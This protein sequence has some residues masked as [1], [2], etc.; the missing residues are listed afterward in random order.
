MINPAT[1]TRRAS[2]TGSG[3]GNRRRHAFRWTLHHGSEVKETTN[4]GGSGPLGEARRYQT[5]GSQRRLQE[6]SR[7]DERETTRGSG[8]HAAEGSS[9]GEELNVSG[10]A[11]DSGMVEDFNILLRLLVALIL[12]GAL[13]WQWSPASASSAPATQPRTS[14]IAAI[15]SFMVSAVS[16]PM[17]EIRKVSP[18]ILP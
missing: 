3:H 16:L 7:I 6:H 18:L 14:S 11:A 9:R 5:I 17:L 4:G 15:N 2:G 8:K 13:S 12:A 10:A 1:R